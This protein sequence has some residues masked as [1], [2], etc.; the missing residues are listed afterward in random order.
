MRRAMAMLGDCSIPMSLLMIGATIGRLFERQFLGEVAHGGKQERDLLLVM[1]HI[2]RLVMK[3]GHQHPV[4]RRVSGGIDAP[5]RPISWST[6][7]PRRKIAKPK[8][9]PGRTK[10][11]SR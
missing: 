2:G 9:L 8:P 5:I 7:K 3:L 11:R 1:A 4:A 6:E 10:T